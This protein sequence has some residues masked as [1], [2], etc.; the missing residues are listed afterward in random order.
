[1][2]V[3]YE[4]GDAVAGTWYSR[5]LHYFDMTLGRRPKGALGHF[6]EDGGEDRPVG[7]IL[8]APAGYHYAG[9]GGRGRQKSLAVVIEPARLVEGDEIGTAIAE[10]LPHFLSLKGQSLRGLLARIEREVAAPG[11]ASALLLDGLCLSLLVETARALRGAN[12]GCVRKG[13]LSARNLRLIEERVR[14][15]ETAPSLPE[16]ASLCQLSLRQLV[17]AFHAETGRT[18]G[19][20]VQHVSL[21][22][23]RQML[24]SSMLPVAEIARKV[25]FSNPSA[26][27][28]AFRRA[29]GETPSSYRKQG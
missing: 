3:D 28:A 17:R 25:G 15:G 23:A 29:C 5:D 27:S 10:G 18:V 1:M 19:D 2:I 4:R 8:F 14:H 9:Q 11:F 22:R 6:V 20:Y 26:F 21:E 12:E 7:P 24:R 16:L 13:G